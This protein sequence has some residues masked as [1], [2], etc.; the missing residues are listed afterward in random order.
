MQNE[1]LGYIFIHYNVSS[2]KQAN[3]KH[4]LSEFMHEA[5]IKSGRN[6]SCEHFF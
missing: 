3:K 6:D 2:F 4:H 5:L 1:C